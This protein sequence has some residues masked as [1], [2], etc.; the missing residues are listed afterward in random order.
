MT[1][2]YLVKIKFWHTKGEFLMNN[3]I[4]F[5][6]TKKNLIIIGIALIIVVIGILAYHPIK[7]ILNP[8]YEPEE[9]IDI[10]EDELNITIFSFTIVEN[11]N[12][13]TH[14]VDIEF[15]QANEFQRRTLVTP[16][17][18][19]NKNTIEYFEDKIFEKI[20]K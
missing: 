2:L 15:Q 17:L 10:L 4:I 19:L 7:E 8:V 6:T 5:T 16:Y 11:E 1:R 18:K 14:L 20:G 9:V 3:K 12:D 13:N